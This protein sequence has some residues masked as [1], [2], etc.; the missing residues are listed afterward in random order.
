MYSADELSEDKNNNGEQK[1]QNETPEKHAAI[2]FFE[3]SCHF[4][5]PLILNHI[6]RQSVRRLK[7]TRQIAIITLR[8][9]V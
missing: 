4:I 7:P 2:V 5:L 1:A 9:H 8:G 6:P 3:I